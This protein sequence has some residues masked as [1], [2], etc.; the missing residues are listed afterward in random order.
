MANTLLTRLEIT[1][2]STRL[3]KNSNMFIQNIDTQYDDQFA[4]SGAKIGSTL[5]I[6]LPNDYIVTDGPGASVQDTAEVQTTLAVA[7]QRHVD[8]GF[9]AAERALSLDDFA[10]RVLPSRR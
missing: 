8:T 2:K 5:R 9:T 10:E 7:T 6:R 1:R 3:F 4:V